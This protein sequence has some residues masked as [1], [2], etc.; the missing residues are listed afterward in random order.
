MGNTQA[1]RK[2]ITSEAENMYKNKIIVTVNINKKTRELY[3][4]EIIN[5]SCLK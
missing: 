2:E 3:Y 4:T 5:S 1:V